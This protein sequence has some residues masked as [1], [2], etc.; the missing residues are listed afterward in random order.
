MFKV[1]IHFEK[2]AG[3]SLLGLLSVHMLDF[4]GFIRVRCE[5][6]SWGS[7]QFLLSLTL[8]FS[9]FRIFSRKIN[10]PRESR[11]HRWQLTSISYKNSFLFVRATSLQVGTV[12]NVFQSSPVLAFFLINSIPS[13]SIAAAVSENITLNR[14]QIALQLWFVFPHPWIESQSPNPFSNRVDQNASFSL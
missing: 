7:I 6:N 11:L 5:I 8:F 13:L 4:P 14:F 2:V 3:Y 10:S 12:C 1:I 9:L